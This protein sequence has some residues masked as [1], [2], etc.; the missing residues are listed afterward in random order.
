MDT[1]PQQVIY[2]ASL[3]DFKKLDIRVGCIIEIEDFL[4]GR[5]STHRLKIDFGEVIGVKK[6]LAKLAPNY[7]GPEL[8]GTYVVAVV[9]F[10]PRQIGKHLSEV[11]VLGVPDGEE[12]VVL[13]RPDR[14]VP[15]SGRVY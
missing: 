12:N 15:P 7:V 1:N 10:P 13:L 6:S 14:K 9:N 3:E 5:H 4:D 2:E 11:L 8:L